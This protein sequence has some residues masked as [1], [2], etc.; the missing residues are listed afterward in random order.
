MP[1]LRPLPNPGPLQVPS[2]RVMQEWR[3]M[4]FPFADGCTQYQVRA[5]KS[6]LVELL[7]GEIDRKFTGFFQAYAKYGDLFI[8]CDFAR[9]WIQ[10]EFPFAEE[11]D[12]EEELAPIMMDYPMS[13]NSTPIELRVIPID[14]TRKVV[15]HKE[16]LAVL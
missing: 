9:V 5:F 11:I 12:C 6:R 3:Q 13:F 10:E 14:R 2:I 4:E 16:E 1:T 7:Q 15:Y 8:R